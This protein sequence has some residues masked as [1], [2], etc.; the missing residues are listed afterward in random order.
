MYLNSVGARAGLTG[1]TSHQ[2][3]AGAPC[4][5]FLEIICLTL[6]SYLGTWEELVQALLNNPFLGSSRAQQPQLLHSPSERKRP[7]PDSWSS[8][9]ALSVLAA[10]LKR[11]RISSP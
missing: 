11:H 10:G 4:P 8:A 5:N 3:V 1:Q 2:F 9:Y 6:P 7:Q